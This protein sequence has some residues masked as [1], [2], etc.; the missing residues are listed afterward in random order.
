[1][2]A[3]FVALALLVSAPSAF[4]GAGDAE[5]RY[6]NNYDQV[7]KKISDDRVSGSLNDLRSEGDGEDEDI[8]L[9]CYDGSVKDTCKLLEIAAAELSD[10]TGHKWEIADCR[11][12]RN[13]IILWAAQSK[14]DEISGGIG[15]TS[16]TPCR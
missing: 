11:E 8:V 5:I 3:A 4:A 10:K 14:R 7:M 13:G 6:G 9:A 15:R 12:G 1:M 2:K 16:L